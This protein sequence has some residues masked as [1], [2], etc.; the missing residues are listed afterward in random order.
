[1]YLY[2]ESALLNVRE[3]LFSIVFTVGNSIPCTFEKQLVTRLLFHG[4]KL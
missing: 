1:M 4:I 2:L 3:I